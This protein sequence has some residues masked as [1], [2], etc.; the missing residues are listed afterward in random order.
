MKNKDLLPTFH[1]LMPA[2]PLTRGRGLLSGEDQT[3]LG[4]KGRG[5][6]LHGKR[7]KEVAGALLW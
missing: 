5:S 6:A 1:H 2:P 4:T 3:G 7:G